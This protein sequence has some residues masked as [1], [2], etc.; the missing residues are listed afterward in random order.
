MFLQNICKHVQEYTASQ[1]RR[2][3][4][5]FHCYENLKSYNFVISVYG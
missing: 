4:S 5:I 1:P 2:P 3:Q